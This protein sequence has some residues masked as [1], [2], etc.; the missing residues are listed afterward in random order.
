MRQ[1]IELIFL[2]AQRLKWIWRIQWARL[3]QFKK[4]VLGD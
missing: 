3:K 2:L 1:L 4:I